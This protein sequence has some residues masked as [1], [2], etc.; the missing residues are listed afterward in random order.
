MY[1]PVWSNIIWLIGLN[2]Q[3]IAT[4][5]QVIALKYISSLCI[6]EGMKFVELN[7][8]IAKRHTTFCY[9]LSTQKSAIC[10]GPQNKIG[11]VYVM[12]Q[13]FR[14]QRQIESRRCCIQ[15]PKHSFDIN[16]E[17]NPSNYNASRNRSWI[18]IEQ[19]P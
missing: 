19:V 13:I 9:L 18:V 2:S 12:K 7:R 14:V 4:A 17:R 1:C 8:N 11:A 5:A 16:L 10:F 3:V 15:W 6:A